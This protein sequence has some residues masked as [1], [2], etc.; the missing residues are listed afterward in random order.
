MSDTIKCPKCG[1][2]NPRTNKFCDSCGAKL[3]AAPAVKDEPKAAEKIEKKKTV[4]PAGEKAKEYRDLAAPVFA[5]AED[6][7]TGAVKG[8]VIINRETLAWLAI[9]LVAI[10]LRFTDL[11]LKPLHHDESMHAFYGYK[12]F[13]GEGYSYN[14]MMHGPFHYHA[15]ALIYFLFGVSDYTARAAPAIYGVIGVILIWFF[16]PYLGRLGAVLTALIIAISPTF[17]YQSRFI[18]EDIFMAVDTIALVIGLFR[19]FDTKKPA[20]LYL[21]AVGLAFSWATKEATY[22]TLFIFGTF[23]FGR[24]IWEYSYRNIP[25]KM[26]KEGRVYS[27]VEYWLKGGGGKIFLYALMI[28]VLV[29]GALYFNKEPNVSFFVNLKGIWDGYVQALVYWLG[30]HSVERGSQP[31]FFYILQIPFYEMQSV[32]FML[33]ASVFYLLKPERRTFFNLFC[34]YWWVMS[35][36]LYSWAGERM[37]WLAIHPLLPMCI[38]AGKFATE[39]INKKEWEWRRALTIAG[40]ILL[41]M[42]SIHGTMNLC[43]YGK[44]ASPKESLVYVQTSTDITRVANKI[45]AFANEMKESK[46]ASQDFRNYDP[47]NMEIV[48]EDYCTWPF[49]WYLRDF[50]KIAYDPK[51]IPRGEM[52]KPLILSGIEEANQGHDERVR[53]MLTSDTKVDDSGKTVKKKPEEIY[54]YTRYKLR[55]WWAPDREKFNKA[56]FGDQF[57]M[58]YDRFMYRDVWNDLGSYDFVVYV[59]QPLEK[60]WRSWDGEE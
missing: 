21:A 23:L 24:W 5:G 54:V 19:Y 31:W 37:P 55:E 30:Q 22:I 50:K 48:C 51:D 35:M 47:T 17:V 44:G 14:P 46:W 58:L 25:E 3:S 41:T 56:G 39:M 15:N 28:F 33:I 10:M 38:L 8:G 1:E 2:E 45:I 18:R 36:A 49:A 59:S 9:I 57:K 13:K 32:V 52:G 42:A 6:M 29:H 12:L 53:Q 20:W 7:E 27:T 4:K 26:Q 16:R 43:F 34:I 11:G 60:Y 40:F